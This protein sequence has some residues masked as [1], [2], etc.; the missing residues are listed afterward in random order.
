MNRSTVTEFKPQTEFTLTRVPT[1]TEPVT[2]THVTADGTA[3]VL[4]PSQ[5]RI[6]GNVLEITD[7]EFAKK[8]KKG[9][10]IRVNYHPSTV[11]PANS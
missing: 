2:V 4:K 8:M 3:T 9:D 11:L 5:Y 1:A 6:A 7:L 10:R